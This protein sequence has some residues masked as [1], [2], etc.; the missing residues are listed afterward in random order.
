MTNRKQTG[1]TLLELAVASIIIAALAIFLLNRMQRY[2]EVAEK[3]VM[4]TTV[5]NMRS[6]LRLRVAELMVQ[7][8]MDEM[9]KLSR[10]NPVSWLEAPPFN[11]VGP[12]DN[13]EQQAIPPGSW[14][15]DTTRRELVYLPDRS[16]H[17]K[18]GPDGEKAVRFRVTAT[19]GQGGGRVEGINISPVSPYDWPV[20]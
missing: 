16:R 3:T 14:Y 17:F 2:Q 20:F 10:E 12:V 4:E 11:Y 13:P 9:D 15:F 8:R 18:P 5:V 1:G 7:G 6:G 19:A